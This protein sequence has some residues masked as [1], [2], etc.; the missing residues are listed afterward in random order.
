MPDR[1]TTKAWVDGQWI[2]ATGRGEESC[3]RRGVLDG[4]WEL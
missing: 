3:F 1:R 2:T 4:V